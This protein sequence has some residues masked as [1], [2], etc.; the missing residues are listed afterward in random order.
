[1]ASRILHILAIT[2]FTQITQHEG[3]YVSDHISVT[4][5]LSKLSKFQIR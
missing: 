2:L 3:T 1:M 5:F 4:K